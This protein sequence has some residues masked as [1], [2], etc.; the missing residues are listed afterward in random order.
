[1]WTT[2]RYASE[3]TRKFA[4]RLASS[5]G[6]VFC[7]RG[8]KTVAQLAGLARRSGEEMIFILEERAGKPF[9]AASARVLETGGWEWAQIIGLDELVAYASKRKLRSGV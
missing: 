3:E 6:S 5:S 2:S 8:K 9:R 7:A 1:M 4:R